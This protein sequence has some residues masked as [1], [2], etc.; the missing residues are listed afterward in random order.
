[1]R[2][3]LPKPVIFGCKLK[4]HQSNHHYSRKAGKIF[5]FRGFTNYPSPQTATSSMSAG[6]QTKTVLYIYLI[7]N[8]FIY[9]SIYMQAISPSR[10]TL[11]CFILGLFLFSN[12]LDTWD[13]FT[14]KPTHTTLAGCPFPRISGKLSDITCRFTQ[15]SDKTSD[16][17]TTRTHHEPHRANEQPRCRKA[18]GRT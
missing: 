1:L 14:A 10:L 18:Q 11:V 7:K 9:R 8:I 13:S 6:V 17:F 5:R 4:A 3:L 12:M 15:R 2:S 16:T